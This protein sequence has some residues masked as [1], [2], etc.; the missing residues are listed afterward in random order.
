M[1]KMAVQI[2]LTSETKEWQVM[3]MRM[4]MVVLMVRLMMMMRRMVVVMVTMMVQMLTSETE[5]GQVLTC[6]ILA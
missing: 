6:S 5:E 1:V 4:M 2:V 3:R